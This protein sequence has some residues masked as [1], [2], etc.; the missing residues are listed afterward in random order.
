MKHEAHKARVHLVK[1][2]HAEGGQQDGKYS[3]SLAD[4]EASAHVPVDEQTTVQPEAPAQAPLTE[5]A[6]ERNAMLRVTGGA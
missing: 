1:A 5:G 2:K 6:V 3:A 4:L